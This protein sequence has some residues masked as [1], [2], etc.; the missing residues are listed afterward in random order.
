M[1]HLRTRVEES[2]LGSL[3]AG[4]IPRP[5]ALYDVV[6][7]RSGLEMDLTDEESNIMMWLFEKRSRVLSSEMLA[8][9]A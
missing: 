3:G 9:W 2:T 5:K 4:A 8:V 7:C 1:T 6:V